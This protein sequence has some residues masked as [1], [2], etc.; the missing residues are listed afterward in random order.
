MAT[1]HRPSVSY[2]FSKHPTL[3]TL[4]RIA[5][6]AH[7]WHGEIYLQ[8][9]F[10]LFFVQSWFM[11]YQGP[12]FYAMTWHLTS[13]ELY[14]CHRG[15]CVKETFNIQALPIYR[16]SP[17][18]VFQQITPFVC[19]RPRKRLVSWPLSVWWSERL[20]FDP[21]PSMHSCHSGLSLPSSGGDWRL[22]SVG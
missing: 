6:F 20:V 13:H 17:E 19:F 10:I 21:Q 9:L 12:M 14:V 11:R 4:V 8:A 2:M 16:S 18:S 3:V 5:Y 15:T 7:G 1:S 22:Q